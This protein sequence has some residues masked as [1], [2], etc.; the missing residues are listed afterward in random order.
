MRRLFIWAGVAVLAVIVASQTL[1]GCA[2]IDASHEGIKI[3]KIGSDR[4]ANDI[5]NVTGWQ[6]Y[7]PLTSF[8]EQ[9][10]TFTQTKDYDPFTVSAKG[11][12]LFKIDP[13]LNY[14]LQ[15]GQGANVYRKYRKELPD[16]E[17]NILR[18][19]VYNSYRDV[20]NTFTPDSLV[21]NRVSF[22]DQVEAKLQKALVNDGF[23]FE[24]ITSN[25]TPPESLQAMIDAKNTAVQNALRLNNQ[26][27]AEKASAEIAVTKATGLA[28]AKVIEAEAEARANELKQ[29]TLT[30]LLIQQQWIAKW[31]GALPTTQLGNSSTMVQ[32]PLK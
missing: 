10:P 22:E 14:H 5:E 31:N 21:N 9:Y 26:V 15:R 27:A 20:A 1:I 11:G 2:T 7:N 30:P 6:F 32:L 19:I 23:V 28:R 18:T 17:N 29:R 12:T 24:N 25:L 3:S 4:G 16:I 8:I 13:T